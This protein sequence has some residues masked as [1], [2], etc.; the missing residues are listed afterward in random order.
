M[1]EIVMGLWELVCE[2]IDVLMKKYSIEERK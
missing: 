2:K 1:K